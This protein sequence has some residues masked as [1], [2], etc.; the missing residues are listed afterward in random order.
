MSMGWVPGV[1]CAA[2]KLLCVREILERES[3]K[4]ADSLS[5]KALI[6]NDL[7]AAERGWHRTR[8]RAGGRWGALEG[9]GRARG[10]RG[11]RGHKK[12]ARTRRR[13]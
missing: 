9:P 12:V 11:A 6:V 8:A 13:F 5:S 1:S 3:A 7:A 10:A 2:A 4:F